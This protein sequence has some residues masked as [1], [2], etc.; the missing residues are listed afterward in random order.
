MAQFNNYCSIKG[1]KE[2]LETFAEKLKAIGYKPCT[3]S[4]TFMQ[5]D[6]YL[7]TYADAVYQFLPFDGN[8]SCSKE[9]AL[10]K[11]YNAALAAVSETV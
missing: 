1:S 3:G 9:F 6:T 5:G 10:P 4:G 2:E 11:Q 7:C 8:A